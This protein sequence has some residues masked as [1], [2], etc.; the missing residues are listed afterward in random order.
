MSS[1]YQ[2][3]PNAIEHASGVRLGSDDLIRSH[4]EQ[5]SIA[6]AE[7][8]PLRKYYK[9]T[10]TGKMTLEASAPSSR[11]QFGYKAAKIPEAT[12]R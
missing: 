8:R 7:Q 2:L 4:W 1:S 3:C 5:Q 12:R 6:D 10:R 11:N 9:L